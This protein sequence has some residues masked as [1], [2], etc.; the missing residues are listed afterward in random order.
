MWCVVVVCVFGGKRKCVRMCACWAE[1]A[2]C[3]GGGGEGEAEKKKK[4][5][6]MPNRPFRL[7][8]DAKR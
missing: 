2:M 5:F 1:E 3:V 8:L 7:E 6:T 4:Y